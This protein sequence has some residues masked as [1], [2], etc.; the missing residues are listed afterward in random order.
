MPAVRGSSTCSNAT[1]SVSTLLDAAVVNVIEYDLN[2]AP[3]VS[4]TPSQAKRYVVPL[5]SL[6]VG[7]NTIASPAPSSR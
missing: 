3:V 2:V 7:W 6:S 4:R 5:A 1:G